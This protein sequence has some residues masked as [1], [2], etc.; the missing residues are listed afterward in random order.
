MNKDYFNSMEIDCGL[1]AAYAV[2]YGNTAHKAVTYRIWVPSYNDYGSVDPLN[3]AY[4]G[5]MM[6]VRG[7]T[8]AMLARGR[9]LSPVPVYG[10]FAE[11]ADAEA[12]ADKLTLT[13]QRKTTA[14]IE[15]FAMDP[16]TVTKRQ[17]NRLF[18][19]LWSIPVPTWE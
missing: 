12:Y 15:M 19:G 8:S 13:V 14:H 4:D 7:V 10:L 2:G 3:A 18:R 11:K 5:E 16:H 17:W 6:R 9:G 1:H